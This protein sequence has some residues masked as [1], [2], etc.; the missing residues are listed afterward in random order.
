LD[1]NNSNYE[2]TQDRYPHIYTASGRDQCCT[3]HFHRKIEL[4]YNMEGVKKVTVNNRDYVLKPHNLCIVDS[5][6]LH[7]YEPT[8]GKQS[9]LTLTTACSE[10]YFQYR[11]NKTLRGN[12]VA[13]QT[14][15]RENLLPY[16]ER[17]LG[18]EKLDAF[19][20]QANVDMLL[21]GICAA[22][23]LQESS[24][25]LEPESMDSILAYIEQNYHT[26]L[27]LTTLA[28]HFGYSKYYFSRIF[29]NMFH[30][31]INDYLS[32]IRLEKTFQYLEANKCSITTAAFNNGFNSMPTFY[33]VLKKN[34]G[35]LPAKK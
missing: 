10:H 16:F 3:T 26:D 29:N 6:S 4:L 13:D 30:T 21:S 22:V 15:C 33:R 2:L 1:K 35:V 32:V 23:G 25:S 31:S 27:T 12:V 8:E 9:I 11:R 18:Y 28:D 17:L 7:Y 34:H 20:V 24:E 14:Y 5:Y 19:S